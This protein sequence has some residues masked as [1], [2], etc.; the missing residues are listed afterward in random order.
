MT[1]SNSRLK[2]P[3]HMPC[4]G[5]LPTTPHQYPAPTAGSDALSTTTFRSALRQCFDLTALPQWHAT[6]RAVRR[7]LQST[8]ECHLRCAG[9]TVPHTANRNTKATRPPAQHHIASLRSVWG[10]LSL[11]RRGTGLFR[12]PLHRGVVY[13]PGLEGNPAPYLCSQTPT[14]QPFGPCWACPLYYE[15]RSNAVQGTPTAVLRLPMRMVFNQKVVPDDHPAP[16]RPPQ[17]SD[18]ASTSLVRHT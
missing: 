15:A 17:E 8:G 4:L 2:S 6:N 14:P 7:A 12:E 10:P 3:A 18:T 9:S 11:Y 13:R 5:A 1:G 16:A